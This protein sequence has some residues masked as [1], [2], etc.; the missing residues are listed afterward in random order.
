MIKKILNISKEE[1][2]NRILNKRKSI[3]LTIKTVSEETGMSQGSISEIEQGKVFPS[4]QALAKLSYILECTTDY[5]LFGNDAIP[6]DNIIINLTC[7]NSSEEDLL[8]IYRSLSQDDKY[9]LLEIAKIKKSKA[10]SK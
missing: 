10:K 1:I 2:G 8:N 7:N 3:K 4:V 6:K 5:L 9:E